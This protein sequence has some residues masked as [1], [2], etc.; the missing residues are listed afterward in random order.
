MH[1]VE[2]SGLI[3]KL[4]YLWDLQIF[5][6]ELGCF[7]YAWITTGKEKEGIQWHQCTKDIIKYRVLAT[8]RK[9]KQYP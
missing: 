6:S 7:L 5:V 2:V 1:L 9:T 4:D 8:N 3:P